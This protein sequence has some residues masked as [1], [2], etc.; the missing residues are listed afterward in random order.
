MESGLDL[1]DVARGINYHNREFPLNYLINVYEPHLAHLYFQFEATILWPQNHLIFVD[2]NFDCQKTQENYRQFAVFRP[3]KFIDLTSNNNN[4][5]KYNFLSLFALYFLIASPSRRWCMD[6]G[7]KKLDSSFHDV[8]DDYEDEN[9]EY[10]EPVSENEVGFVPVPGNEVRFNKKYSL[11]QEVNYLLSRL[12]LPR[13]NV[14]N[15]HLIA[16]VY[17]CWKQMGPIR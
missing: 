9:A 10:E 14:I 16:S 2:K 12:I 17:G 4:V 5:R 3:A 7:A 15:P 8:S 1:F 6:Y 11:I 13:I